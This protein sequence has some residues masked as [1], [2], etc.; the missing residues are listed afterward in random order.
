MTVEHLANPQNLT[1]PA[2]VYVVWVQE[3]GGSPENQGQL[4][5]DKNLKAQFETSR[6]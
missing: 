4:K 1:P 5:V 3:T 2:S 6:R